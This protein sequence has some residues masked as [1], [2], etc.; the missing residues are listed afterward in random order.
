MATRIA[1]LSEA[2]SEDPALA[3]AAGVVRWAGLFVRNFELTLYWGV[4]W[5]LA[6]LVVL[7]LGE[8]V[9]ARRGTPTR[10]AIPLEVIPA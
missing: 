6:H 3:R 10:L 5:A 9:F 7:L 1:D 8:L 2:H 4:G